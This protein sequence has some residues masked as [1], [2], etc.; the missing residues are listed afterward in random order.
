MA[1]EEHVALLRQGVEAWNAWHEENPKLFPD[2][3]GANLKG[4]ILAGANLNGADL[5]NADLTGCHVHG[6]S[7]WRLILDGTTQKDLGPVSV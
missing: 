6:V 3:A 2:L 4:A 7:A 1:N 5:A